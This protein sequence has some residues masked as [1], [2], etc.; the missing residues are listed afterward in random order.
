[1]DCGAACYDPCA[2]PVGPLTLVFSIFNPEHWD[3][4]CGERY[5]GDFHGDPPHCC[6]PCDHMGN[7]TGGGCGCS[8]TVE[9]VVSTS[10]PIMVSQT[11]RVVSPA[12]ATRTVRGVAPIPDPGASRRAATQVRR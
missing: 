6:D 7:Y 2:Y 4:G 5:W 1:M 9:G 3:G 10:E 11:D 12:R 8:S